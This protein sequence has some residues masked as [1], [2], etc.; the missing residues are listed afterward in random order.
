VTGA[1]LAH[2]EKLPRLSFVKL[3][4]TKVERA[5]ALKFKEAMNLPD[6]KLDYRKGAF[7][8]VG[9]MRIEN[10][11]VLSTVHAGSPAEK[12]GLQRDDVLV[13]FGDQ[14]VSDFAALTAMISQLDSRDVAEIEVQREVEDGDGNIR[15]KNIVVKATL[16][17]WDVKLAV[18]N[19]QKG[20][21]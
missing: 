17:P 16:V 11:C 4:G 5:G 3:Y 6:D 21:P 12:A 15:T 1:A 13:R 2:L 19:G 14:K 20:R 7:L 9:C 18:E 8:G 10:A